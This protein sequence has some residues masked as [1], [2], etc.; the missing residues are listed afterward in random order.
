MRLHLYALILGTVLDLCIGDPHS[1]PHPVAAIGKC[2]HFLDVRF[3]R[4][5]Q[6]AGNRQNAELFLGAL[7]ELLVTAG[8]GAVVL[9]ILALFYHLS[10]VAGMLAEAVMTCQILAARSL[11]DESGKVD[12][13]LRDG[14]LEDGRKAVSMIVGRDTAALTEAGVI[15]AAVETVAENTSDGVIAPMLYTAL[16]GPVAGFVYKAIN[17]MDSMVGYQNDTYL[18]FGRVPARTDDAA[19]FIPSRLSALFMIAAASVGGKQFSAREAFRIWRR[20]R[21]K[22]RSPN[23]AQTEAVMA[24]ALGVR[25]AGPAS[26]FGKPV[27]KPWIGDARR[28][29][30]KEDIR[31]A[32]RL[33]FLTEGLFFALCAVIGLCIEMV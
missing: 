25:L 32:G 13:A 23:S 28:E 8:T 16:G 14:T 5:A 22:H 31:R 17:T 7:M 20:D 15:R 18:Y 21:R 6:R 2:I 4:A 26:Y 1:I 27:K 3:R 11:Y 30:E 9:A 10:P 19:N 29:I 12:T 33:M 24:G